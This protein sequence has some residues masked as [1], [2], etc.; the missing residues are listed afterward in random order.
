MDGR[1]LE[2]EA[3]DRHPI[4][5]DESGRAGGAPGAS[6]RVISG[7]GFLSH[8][9]PSGDVGWPWMRRGGGVPAEALP[10]YCVSRSKKISDF[11]CK[12]PSSREGIWAREER[13]DPPSR[14]AHGAQST[15]RHRVILRF[16]A[17]ITAR[18]FVGDRFL[19]RR[20]SR[21]IAEEPIGRMGDVRREQQL[22][23]K[24]PPEVLLLN[25]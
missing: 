12:F 15:A 24:S 1:R 13:I 14:F 16:A 25:T 8:Y 6:A 4:T 19:V 3:E 18:A 11:S 2:A 7:C 20:G 23:E 22:G 17:D 9:L 10:F 5:M 21:R